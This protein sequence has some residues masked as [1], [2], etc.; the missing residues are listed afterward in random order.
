MFQLCPAAPKTT[1]CPNI[2]LPGC[3]CAQGIRL[4]RGVLLF[5]QEHLDRLFEGAKALDMDLGGCRG[6][7]GDCWWAT[8][9][10]GRE[11]P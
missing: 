7:A 2:C 5:A 3:S 10:E 1:D 9:V 8:V 4:H 11:A 6:L